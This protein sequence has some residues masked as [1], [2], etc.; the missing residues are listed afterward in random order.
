MPQFNRV[1]LLHL[2]DAMLHLPASPISAKEFVTKI[3]SVPFRIIFWI[4][5]PFIVLCLLL[6]NSMPMFG[7]L[8]LYKRC[9]ELHEFMDEYNLIFLENS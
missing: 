2:N 4:V 9:A 6:N 1:L 7:F 5:D 8:S 3:M